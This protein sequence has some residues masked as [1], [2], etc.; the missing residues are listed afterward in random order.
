MVFKLVEGHKNWRRFDGPNQCQNP[1]S[2]WHSTTGV[3]A[4]PTDRQPKNAAA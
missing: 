3:I 4:K 2:A 1:F